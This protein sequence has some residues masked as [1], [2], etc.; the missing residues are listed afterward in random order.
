[1]RYMIIVKAT[2]DSEAG[3]MPPPELFEVMAEYHERL[4]AAGVLVDGSGLHP[5]SKGFRI[6]WNG[7]AKTVTDGPFA[8]TKE[9]VAGYT[10]IDVASEADARRWAMDFPNPSLDDGAIDLVQARHRV[11]D[12]R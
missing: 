1:M 9:L 2:A 11:P 10:L 6:E 3:K 8:E 4:A 5:S 12:D 7:G